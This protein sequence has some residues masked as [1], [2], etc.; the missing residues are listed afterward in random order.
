MRN[1]YRSSDAQATK[2]IASSSDLEISRRPITLWLLLLLFSLTVV[3]AYINLI[4]E[5][6]V[7]PISRDVSTF[8]MICALA[9]FSAA[10]QLPGLAIA[11]IRLKSSRNA[12]LPML[13]VAYVIALTGAGLF[14]L[15][16]LDTEPA[17]SV[18]SAGHMYILLL[19]VLHLAFSFVLY[20]LALTFTLGVM[21]F[22]FVRRKDVNG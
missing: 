8:F 21:F 16:A 20:L 14:L 10:S 12:L 22:R 5:E 6:S 7:G 18:N 1:P 13:C 9:G 19:P 11:T 4:Q 3:L 17:D 2:L 15:V